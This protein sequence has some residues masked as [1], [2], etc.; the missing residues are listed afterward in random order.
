MF[1]FKDHV[2]Y[3]LL[4]GVV[5]EY[6]FSRYNSSY[7]GETERYLKIRS[8]EHVGISLLTFKITKPSKESLIRDHLLQYVNNSS[9]DEFTIL[10]HGNKTYLLEIKESLLVKCN[11]PFLNKN[12]RS[13]TLR[14]FDTV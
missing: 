11:Q 7:Y 8:G 12:I 4:P 9:F 2:A 14:L 3:D 5:Y 6:T 10:A 13:A 1:R